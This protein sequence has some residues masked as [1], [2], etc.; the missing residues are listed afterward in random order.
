VH[1]GKLSLYHEVMLAG[2]KDEEELEQRPVDERSPLRSHASTTDAGGHHQS[3]SVA[4]LK[5][6]PF[7][8]AHSPVMP[9]LY[10]DGLLDDVDT[11]LDDDD[12][13]N[14]TH[15]VL[16]RPAGAFFCV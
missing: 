2:M 12:P 5:S 3:T 1:K 15:G 9:N 4:S 14:T 8:P 11:S 16:R 6:F 7:A 10:G 13:L